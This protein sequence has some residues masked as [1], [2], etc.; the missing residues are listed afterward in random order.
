MATIENGVADTRRPVV[1]SKSRTERVLGRAMRM[2]AVFDRKGTR[3]MMQAFPPPTV[4]VLVNRGR[5]SGRLYRTPLSILAEDPKRDE[6]VV[7]PMWSKDSDWYRNVIAGG[8]VE[9]H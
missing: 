3:W 7:S 9:I 8:L 2:P 4:I 5:A 1:R 6:I